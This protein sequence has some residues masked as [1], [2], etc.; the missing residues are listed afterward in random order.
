MESARR[1]GGTGKN[2]ALQPLG[3][4]S[5]DLVRW[6]SNQRRRGIARCE[7]PRQLRSP[8][9][10]RRH[11]PAGADPSAVIEG[12]GGSPA[13][14]LQMLQHRLQHAMAVST[15]QR[16]MAVPRQE[17]GNAPRYQR[18]EPTAHLDRHRVVLFAVPEVA[19]DT[20]GIDIEVPRPRSTPSSWD[21]P[22]LP[23]RNAPRSDA[24]SVAATA[25]PSSTSRS[26]DD[27]PAASSVFSSSGCHLSTDPS[28]RL[29]VLDSTGAERAS[30]NDVRA[31]TST[32]AKS[33]VTTVIPR[34]ATIA[35]RSPSPQVSCAR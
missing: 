33:S 17:M 32:R 7:S 5:C 29:T 4:R 24:A 8:E 31:N 18:R 27:V 13:V 21:A 25:A 2:V 28:A 35:V 1:L 26:G 14:Q 10:S 19:G 23:A 11:R 3:I 9:K 20:D 16:E 34:P 15:R 12:R 22:S 6:L 30:R